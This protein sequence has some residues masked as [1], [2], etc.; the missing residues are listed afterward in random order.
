MT[1]EAGQLGAGAAAPR[2]GVLASAKTFLSTLVAIVG[3]RLEILATE[4]EE[5]RLRLGSIV[6]WAACTL[7]FAALAL[8]FL[9]LL[10][11]VVFWDDHRVAALVCVSLAYL[12]LGGLSANQLY[13]RLMRRSPLFAAT[14]DELRKD[15]VGL[16]S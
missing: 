7:L 9:S 13:K 11:V 5:E 14:L 10:V 16:Q 12:L 1:M 15:Q 6:A 2:L 8:I 3:T 4:L